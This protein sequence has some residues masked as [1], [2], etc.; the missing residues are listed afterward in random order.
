ML[1]SLL[2]TSKLSVEPAYEA[3]VQAAGID[4][5]TDFHIDEMYGCPVPPCP[6]G[7]D[8]PSVCTEFCQLA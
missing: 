3:F 6:G 7:W 5:S 8:F 2:L 1:A 4:G